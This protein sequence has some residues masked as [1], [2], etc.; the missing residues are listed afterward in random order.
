MCD[1]KHTIS[2]NSELY[3]LQVRKCKITGDI[4]HCLIKKEKNCFNCNKPLLQKED[5]YRIVSYSKDMN[6]MTNDKLTIKSQYYNIHS[7]SISDDEVMMC[8][9][10]ATNPDMREVAKEVSQYK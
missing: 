5:D 6:Q 3:N 10:C 7:L 2:Y 8:K 4:Y 1:K 9:F